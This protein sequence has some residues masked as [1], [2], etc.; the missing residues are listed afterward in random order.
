MEMGDTWES[1]SIFGGEGSRKLSPDES[2]GN[3]ALVQCARQRARILGKLERIVGTMIS[4]DAS[5]LLISFRSH[6][7]D[8]FGF[9]LPRRREGRV[10]E[11]SSSGKQLHH[12]DLDFLLDSLHCFLPTRRGARDWQ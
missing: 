9:D 1:A 6:P 3:N 10:L 7:I 5:S 4:D 2:L 11:P 8:S 12:Q